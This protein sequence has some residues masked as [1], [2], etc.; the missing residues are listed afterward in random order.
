[1]TL[2]RDIRLT[3]EQIVAARD[4]CRHRRKE[5]QRRLR[6][7]SY[8]G[9]PG[10]KQSVLNELATVQGL[11]NGFEHHRQQIG[12]QLAAHVLGSES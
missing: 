9:K 2:T 11:E 3:A 7:N 12:H 10:M 5:L 8:E 4:A 1:V 6:R